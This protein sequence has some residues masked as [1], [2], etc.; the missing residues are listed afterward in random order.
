MNRLNLIRGVAFFSDRYVVIEK[1]QNHL[2][3]QTD[4]GRK[5]VFLSIIFMSLFQD[6]SIA[7][8]MNILFFTIWSYEKLWYVSEYDKFVHSKSILL[9]LTI[10]KLSIDKNNIKDIRIKRRE[11][12]EGGYDYCLHFIDLNG[13]EYKITRKSRC[14]ELIPIINDIK[15]YLPHIKVFLHEDCKKNEHFIEL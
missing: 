4:S 7:I 15:V 13:Y 12:G 2:M 14:R 10:K 9:F 8:I 3:I 5:I 6:L 11:G 1:N